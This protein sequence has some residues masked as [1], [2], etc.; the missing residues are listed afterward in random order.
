MKGKALPDGEIVHL[1]LFMS[2]RMVAVNHMKSNNFNDKLTTNK[3]T[4]SNVIMLNIE[5]MV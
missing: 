3:K 2:G 4:L 1:R 5:L